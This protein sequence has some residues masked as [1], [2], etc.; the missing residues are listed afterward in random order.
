V[1]VAATR[2]DLSRASESEAIDAGTLFEEHSDRLFAYCLR[3]L[4]SRSEAE[5]ALQTTFLYAHRALQ[6][7]V[8]PQ[9]EYPWLHAIAKNV[10]RWQ[11]RTVARRGQLSTA[12][13]LDAF[14]GR[15]EDGDEQEL[16]AGLSDALASIP[17]GQR[18]ALVLR[19]WHGLSSSEVAARLGM[20]A[21]ATYALLTRARKSLAQALTTGARRPLHGLNLGSLLFKLKGL[22]AGGT[23]KA[24]AAGVAVGSVAIGG[25]AI[26]KTLD[27][28]TP[29]SPTP[30]AAV[31]PRTGSEL[32]GPKAI[33][34]SRSATS[35]R[36][37]GRSTRGVSTPTGPA[38][39]LTDPGGAAIPGSSG[40]APAKPPVGDAGSGAGPIATEPPK[41][42]PTTPPLPADP[43]DLLPLPV[44]EL[45]P[46]P[47]PE[48]PPLP[49]EVP[50]LD[51]VPAVEDIVPDPAA[52]PPLP[53]LE[54]PGPSLPLPLPV[55]LPVP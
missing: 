45:L 19:E 36:M 10:C 38:T 29:S 13:D 50:P 32:G 25:I 9:A 3:Y 47:V 7:G 18:R 6:R 40:D 42:L 52:T 26:E 39:P 14:P 33:D 48:L 5:D 49:V 34:A 12:V 21:P 27:A 43:T 8:V 54:L 37:P 55:P 53:A 44:P 17:E 16:L 28:G 4:G 1:A 22:L 46:L 35:Q 41:Q 31:D 20:S 23:A 2:L 15:E 11:Q 24:V 30:P 51:E